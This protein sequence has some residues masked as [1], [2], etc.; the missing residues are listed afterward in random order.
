MNVEI[1][2][3]AAQFPEKEYISGILV[4]VRSIPYANS[5]CHFVCIVSPLSLYFCLRGFGLL[6]GIILKI[7]I[8]LSS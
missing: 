6:H 3:E 5:V 7:H 1:G 8:P 4:A 2:I